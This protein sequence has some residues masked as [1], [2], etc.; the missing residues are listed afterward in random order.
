VPT[1]ARTPLILTPLKAAQL[2]EPSSY[3]RSG[4]LGID[5]APKK[6]R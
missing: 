6:L 4:W 3:C 5:I 2:Y 1:S